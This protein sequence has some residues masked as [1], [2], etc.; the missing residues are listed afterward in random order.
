MGIKGLKDRLDETTFKSLKYG[1]DRPGG[2]DSGQP[3][4]KVDINT[5]DRGFNRFRMTKF[6]DGLIRG[7]VVGA[8]NASIVDTLR[9]GKFLIDFPKGPLFIAK[10]VGLQMSNPILEHKTDF[11]TNKETKGQGLFRNIGNFVSNTANKVL[12]SVG[13]TRIYNLGINTLA[14]VPLNAFGQ[15][16]TRHG[17]LPKQDDDNLYYKVAQ[18]NNNEA[19]NRLTGLRNRFSLGLNYNSAKGNI[20][21][22][23]KEQKTLGAIAFAYEGGLDFANS[24]YNDIQNSRIDDYIGGPGSIYGI[25][26]TL[27]KRVPEHTNDSFKIDFAKN[28]NFNAQH[29]PEVKISSSF[30]FGVSLFTSSGLG[31]ESFDLIKGQ[32]ISSSFKTF[33][34]TTNNKEQVLMVTKNRQQLSY[35]D[36]NQNARSGSFSGLTTKYTSSSLATLTF[37]NPDEEAAP[38]LNELDKLA[39]Y[40]GDITWTPS[41]GPTTVNKY[42]DL[43]LSSL[44]TSNKGDIDV[45]DFPTENE[46]TI[47]YTPAATDNTKKYAELRAKVDAGNTIVQTHFKTINVNVSRNDPNFKYVKK[48]LAN[49]F[50]RTNDTTLTDDNLKLVFTPLDPFTGNKLNTLSFLGYITDYSENYDS[51]WGDVKYIGRAEK[52]YI[53]NEFKRTVSVGFNVPCFNAV[54]LNNKHCALS[55]LASTLAG[56]YSDNNLLGGI[57]TKLKVGNYIDNQPG[58]ITNLTFSPIQDSSWDLDAQLAF[59]LKVSF[60]FTLIHNFLPEYTSCG[61]INK[62]ATP[63]SQDNSE[64]NNGE[65]NNGASNNGTSNN[66]TSN[67]TTS[68]DLVMVNPATADI[69]SLPLF[70]QLQIRRG[71]NQNVSNDTTTPPSPRADRDYVTANQTATIDPKVLPPP[72]PLLQPDQTQTSAFIG[73]IRGG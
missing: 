23:K 29:L 3:Y 38:G 58:I 16:I 67:D 40:T 25:G 71:M 48:E 10:Q 36:A 43:G 53:F 63:V 73:I 14:Q 39:T 27:I 28:R 56:K 26:R 51:S 42:A 5:I 41:T 60:G 47:A 54:E 66:G 46:N 34:Q 2:G 4:E 50:E 31:Y 52:F 1:H 45:T 19:N 69:N 17:F 65:S 30:D 22:R 49:K 32:D 33:D 21:L 57:I 37:N 59:Y 70:Q 62:K 18:Y 61:F 24:V 7:G 15:H 20:K 68:K 11:V 44:T 9:I 8:A 64:S 35:I 13:P 6:D 72:S 55:E 12:N